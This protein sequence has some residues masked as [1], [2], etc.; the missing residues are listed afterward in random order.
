MEQL[1]GI[2]PTVIINIAT[3]QIANICINQFEFLSSSLLN[4][5]HHQ[6]Q[7]F[8]TKKKNVDINCHKIIGVVFFINCNFR[9]ALETYKELYNTVFIG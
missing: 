2:Q 1:N 8:Y 7:S 5:P 6:V 3:L 4:E 9:V